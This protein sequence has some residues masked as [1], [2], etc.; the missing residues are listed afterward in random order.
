[1]T[2]YTITFREVGDA[3][4]TALTAGQ[5]F[6]CDIEQYEEFFGE[7]LPALLV[8]L[9]RV[10]SGIYVVD[11]L[12]K[13]RRQEQRR[14]W[15]RSLS[16][17]VGLLE[18]DFWSDQ[19]AHA[20]LTETV[21]FLTDDTWEFLFDKDDRRRGRDVQK[22]LFRVPPE[23]RVC[24]YSGGLDSAAGLAN[25]IVNGPQADV[26]PVTIWHQPIQRKLIQKQHKLLRSKYDVL[27]SPLIVKAALIWTPELRRFR[28]E[29][30]QRRPGVP[31]RCRRCGRRCNGWCYLG[32]D[33]RVGHRGDQSAFH[34]R[35]GRV[36]ND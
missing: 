23:S 35:H 34:G 29:L 24:L 18:P 2:P 20:A 3:Q 5:D 11:R 15:S 21:E 8:D 4:S 28:E 19:K 36:T 9:L 10:A 16:L 32:R 7:P 13:R 26:L 25:Q 27:I 22:T 6:R 12:V 17:K 14:R 1:M 31:F 30:T 33:I